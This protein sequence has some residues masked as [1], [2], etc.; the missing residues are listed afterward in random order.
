M[1]KSL[2]CEIK[3]KCCYCEFA[4]KS[5]WFLILFVIIKLIFAKISRNQFWIFSYFLGFNSFGRKIAKYLF[6]KIQHNVYY[7][8]FLDY[9]KKSNISQGK[10]NVLKYLCYVNL[11]YTASLLYLI[12][13]RMIYFSFWCKYV[14]VFQITYYK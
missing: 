13:K 3:Q 11:C 12:L 9:I 5:K 8:M 6:K 10:F 1:E 4:F 7:R 14:L 2:L